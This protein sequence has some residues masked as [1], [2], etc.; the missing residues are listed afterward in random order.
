MRIIL[1]IAVSLSRVVETAFGFRD[2]SVWRC[3]DQDPS[4]LSECVQL[5]FFSWGGS[6][7]TSGSSSP[8]TP[9]HGPRV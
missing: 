7:K 9:R 1:L 2:L 8:S 5:C 6:M 4:S 3:L